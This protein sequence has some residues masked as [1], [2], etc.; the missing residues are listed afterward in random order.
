MK[1]P[2]A[3]TETK[4]QRILRKAEHYEALAGKH[5]LKPVLVILMAIIETLRESQP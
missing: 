2:T 3:H 1:K 5:G 4:E